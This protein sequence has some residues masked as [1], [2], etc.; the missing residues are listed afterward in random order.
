MSNQSNASQSQTD[1]IK[2][3]LYGLAVGDQIGGP[4][5]MALQLSTALL[6]THRFDAK[7]VLR[8]Y[9][10]WWREAGFDTGNVVHNV[11]IEMKRGKLNLEAVETIHRQTNGMTGGCNPMHRASPLALLKTATFTDLETYAM[12]DAKLTHYDPIAGECSAFVVL[13]CRRILEGATINNA[14]TT[15]YNALNT[16]SL[17]KTDL[18]DVIT[19]DKANPQLEKPLSNY[20]YSPD[21]LRATVYMLKTNDT[22]EATLESAFAFAGVGNYCPVVVGAIAGAYYGYSAIPR[23]LFLNHHAIVAHELDSIIERFVQLWNTDA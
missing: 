5:R 14:L 23:Q 3:L 17:L 20:G 1:R 10:G 8:H 21:V 4:I 2:G 13:T 15:T 12:Q 6:D 16:N 11:F 9:Y 19:F 7:N 18:H 22:F